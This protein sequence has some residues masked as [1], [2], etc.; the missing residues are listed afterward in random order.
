MC[1]SGWGRITESNCYQDLCLQLHLYG[2]FTVDTLKPNWATNPELR[3]NPISDLFSNWSSLPPVV[4]VVL[5]VP[6]QRLAVF[7]DNL[8]RIGNPTLQGGLWVPGVQDN[9]YAAIYLAWGK[10][11]TSTNSNRVVIEEDPSGQQ[12]QSDLVVTFWISTR[13]AEIPGTNVY[14]R[15]RSTPQSTFAL[16]QK[17][18]VLLEVFQASILDKKYVRVLTYQPALASETPQTPPSGPSR[19]PVDIPSDYLCHA[20]TSNL[21]SARIDSLSIRFDVQAKE[22]QD[23]L[24]IGASVT[25]SQVSACTMELKIGA[26]SHLLSYP[27]PIHGNNNKLH[28]ARK[29]LYVEVVVPVSTPNDYSGYFLNPSPVINPGAYTVWNLH[30]VCLDRLPTLDLKSPT[31]L[32]WLNTLTALQLS[33][34]ENSIISGDETQKNTA[35]NALVNVKNSIHEMTMHSSGVQG[36]RTRNI[37]LCDKSQGGIYV[38]LL[39]GAIKLDSASLTIV[40]DTAIIPLSNER[41]P[42]LMPEIQKIYDTANLAQVSTVGHEV[43]AWKKL[44]PAFAERCRNW[45]HRPNCE[46]KSQGRVPISTV[47]DKNPICTCG[48]GIGFRSPEW[49]APEWKSL[50]PFATR[51]AISP[52]YSVSYIPDATMKNLCLQLHLYGVFTVDTLKPNWATNPELRT[53]PISD[54]FSNWSSLPPV[55]CVVLTVPRQ[56][57]AVFSDNL[58]RIGN[59]TL[60]GG[61]WVPGVQDNTYAAI[62]LAWGKC[63]TSTNSNRVVIEEDPS[64]QQGQSDLVVTFWISTHVAEIPGTNVYLRVRSTPQSTFALIQKL[65]ALLEV[66]Q[67]S[68]L[69]KKYTPQTPPSGPSRSPVDIPSDYLCHAIAS[70]LHSARINSLSIRFDVQAKEEQDHLWIGASVTASQVSACT[71]ELKIGAHSHLL[72]YPYPI[73][74]N[75][76]KLHIARKSLYV[77]VGVMDFNLLQD[78][79]A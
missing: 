5:T 68:I 29:S 56:Q 49:R 72:S 32:N 74:G 78:I 46:Y 60:Q 9:T 17:L 45:S 35:I 34:R 54:L 63:V 43:T 47:F 67:A 73:H 25:A 1:S 66:F 50:L 6:R 37:M 65:G 20:I 79:Y 40:L 15:V 21:H 36:S 39:I 14:L 62:Y 27:Y 55:V 13:V 57:L 19:S 2:V 61:L 22:E 71:M 12:G 38:L 24:R 4:C 41:M 3:T 48:Q 76:N 52:I 70:N 10:C 18:G 44:I 58:E 42:V 69:D 75:N 16:I 77:E 30:H 53:N 51:A 7:S 26:H 33:E 28:I 64:G 23:H 59:P 8:E 31:K 11:V